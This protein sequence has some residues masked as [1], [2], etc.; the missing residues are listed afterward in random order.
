MKDL[1]LS[2]ASSSTSQPSQS[3]QLTA[4]IKTPHV[5]A[6]F[7]RAVPDY[8]VVDHTARIGNQTTIPG[9]VYDT[10]TELSPLAPPLTKAEFTKMWRTLILRRV[11]DIYDNEKCVRPNHH[12][13]IGRTIKLPAPL[14]D[15]LYSLGHFDSV[16]TGHRHHVIPPVME[17]TPAN[18]W[19]KDDAVIGNWITFCDRMESFYQMRE[20]PAVSTAVDKPMML[21]TRS[22]Q[23]MNVPVGTVRVNAVTNEPN[24]AEA[25][26]FSLHD[27]IFDEDPHFS[28]ANTALTMTPQLYLTNMRMQYVESYILATHT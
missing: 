24:P 12:V 28:Y 17:A 22:D 11:Q 3:A 18:W 4:F 8:T 9:M 27:P 13:K 1:S 5:D 19:N 2:T 6:L 25:L 16:A 15:L 21:C 20:Y 23:A 10:L 14:A 26:V 7:G